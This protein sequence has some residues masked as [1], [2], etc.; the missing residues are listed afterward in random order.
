MNDIPGV[1]QSQADPPV[2]RR[3]DM[4]IDQLQFL[5][6]NLRLVGLNGAVELAD[7]RLLGIELLACDYSRLPELLVAVEVYPRVIL[8]RDIF[9]ELSLRLVERHLIRSR[10]NL[11]EHIADANELA[12][13]EIHG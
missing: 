11:G 8:R 5:I 6:V 12:L 13:L 3:C 9:G 2:D 7:G 1:N 4:A 10:V